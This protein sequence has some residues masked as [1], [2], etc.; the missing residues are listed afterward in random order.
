[1]K[2]LLI[3]VTLAA[4]C[5]WILPGCMITDYPGYDGKKTQGLSRLAYNEVAQYGDTCDTTIPGDTDANGTT[6][7]TYFR[8]NNPRGPAL[9]ENPIVCGGGGD[10]GGDGGP[11]PEPNWFYGYTCESTDPVN[12]PNRFVEIYNDV[13]WNNSNLYASW[14]ANMWYCFSA[15]FNGSYV[16]NWTDDRPAYWAWPDSRYSDPNAPPGSWYYCP[17]GA[18]PRT[19]DLSQRTFALMCE[20]KPA[21]SWWQ[22]YCYS[23]LSGGSWYSYCYSSQYLKTNYGWGANIVACE[24]DFSTWLPGFN[25][26]S[27]T[28]GPGNRLWAGDLAEWRCCSTYEFTPPQDMTCPYNGTG[29]AVAFNGATAEADDV[30]SDMGLPVDKMADVIKNAAVTPNGFMVMQVS[31]IGIGSKK[32]TF[33]EP[34]TLNMPPSFD[35]IRIPLNLN[36]PWLRKAAK[37]ILDAGLTSGQP[38]LT[39][40]GV[41]VKIDARVILNPSWL[42]DRAGVGNN[43]VRTR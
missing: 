27:K 22:R 13:M 5:I 8:Y 12:F 10:E 9:P 35:K 39:I 31:A 38:T 32:V 3:A 17:G 25:P 2:K 16:R 41:D 40:N 34:W 7:I 20:Q 18:P 4:L 23:Y 43:I 30:A 29:L 11:M 15:H 26:A 21:E 37:E 42:R 28:L 6:G 1:M 19:Q 36:D 24:E 33:S 14:E